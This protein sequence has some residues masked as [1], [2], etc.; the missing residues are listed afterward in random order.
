MSN[1]INLGTILTQ[2]GRTTANGIA[3]G[4][5]SATLIDGILEGR[6]VTVD[7][8]KDNIE[9]NN[10][11]VS[12]LGDLR[13]LLERFQSASNVLR[14]PPGVN[15]ASS[16]LFQYTTSTLSSN[17]S[18]AASEYLSITSEPGATVNSYLVDNISLA[19]EHVRVAR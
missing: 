6:Q 11:K 5:D 17:T 10:T 19:E 7:K 16:N 15:N 12:A 13:L 8:L 4:L 2:N 3:S 14:N 18:V 1:T 9:T